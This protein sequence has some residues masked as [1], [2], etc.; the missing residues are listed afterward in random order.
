MRRC[1]FLLCFF[2]VIRTASAADTLSI[3]AASDLV[4]CLEKLN[5]AF[6]RTHADVQLKTSVGSSGNFFAQIRNGAPFDVFLSADVAYPRE[7][8]TAGSA[9]AA[10][11]TPYAIGRIVLWTTRADLD[12][13]SGI[14]AAGQPA[15]KR[16]AIA[17]PAHAPYGRAAR[18]ALEQ[19]KQW[20][21]VQPRLVFGENISQTAQFVETGNADAGIVALSLVLSPR[22]KN[23]GRYVEISESAHAPLEQ[24]A[25]LTTRGAAN[26]HARAY[27][28]FLRSAEARAV[29]DE[30]GFRLPN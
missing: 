1:L 15:I 24:A 26:A 19:A 30:F 18:E 27:L 8:I 5:A 29:F 6:S 21:S 17:N 4:F 25:V 23:V 10:S 3:A 2:G 12:L 20:E 13:S 11:L 16:L 14:S 9:D 7:L 28:E 22:L